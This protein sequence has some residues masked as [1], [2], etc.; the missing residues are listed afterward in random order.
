MNSTSSLTLKALHCLESRC[1]LS[2]HTENDFSEEHSIRFSHLYTITN[3]PI[4]RFLSDLLENGNY[5][6]YM[7]LLADNY[8]ALAVKNL[9]CRTTISVGWDGTLYDCDFNQML[10]LPTAKPAPQHIREFSEEAL[11]HRRITLGQHCYGCTAGA[12]SSCHGSLI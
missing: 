9:M 1:S 11:R 12:G 5:C 6:T 3:M 7:T 4:S 10:H 2:R 8:N